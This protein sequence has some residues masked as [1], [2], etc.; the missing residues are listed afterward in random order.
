MNTPMLFAD[1][2]RDHADLLLLEINIARRADELSQ[3]R[4]P[5]CNWHDDVECWLEAEREML[6]AH[7]EPAFA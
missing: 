5:S 4:G 1:C 6:C 7:A 2:V 3:L